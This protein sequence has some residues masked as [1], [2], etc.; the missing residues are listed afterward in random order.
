LNRKLIVIL[1]GLLLIAWALPVSGHP[2]MPSLLSTLHR[3]PFPLQIYD[4][5]LTTPTRA[6]V[7]NFTVDF[8]N[9][10][11]G[12]DSFELVVDAVEVGT[13]RTTFVYLFSDQNL[14]DWLSAPVALH[15]GQRLAYWASSSP[16]ICDGTG[17]CGTADSF[18]F[19]P[20]AAG[21]YHV[22]IVNQNA[23]QN[24]VPGVQST[25]HVEIHGH[26]TWTTTTIG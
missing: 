5:T 9:K 11:V 24:L 18:H 15:S 25:Y 6:F 1:A 17:F 10:D 22:A 19:A 12:S 20:P 8:A 13:T 3:N 26:E 16:V 2:P 4:V 21:L 7:W 14:T 23:L